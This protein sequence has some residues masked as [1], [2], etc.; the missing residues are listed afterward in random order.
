MAVKLE[1]SKLDNPVISPPLI[2]TELSFCSDIV[3]SLIASTTLEPSLYTKFVLPA[4]TVIPVPVEFL[5]TISLVQLLLIRYNFCIVGTTKF[6]VAPPVVP[7]KFN[8][9]CLAA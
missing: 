8:L 3:P 6:L 2:S 9:K 5:T 4:P 7:I 1:V